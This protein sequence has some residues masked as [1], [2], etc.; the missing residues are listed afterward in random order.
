MNTLGWRYINTTT[1][2]IKR[3]RKIDILQLPLFTRNCDMVI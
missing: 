2:E 3:E 1:M